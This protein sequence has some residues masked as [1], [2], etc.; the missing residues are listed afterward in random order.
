VSG[1]TQWQQTVA[2]WANPKAFSPDGKSIAV[3]CG[4]QSIRFFDTETGT[5]KHE[6]KA[7]D[8]PQGGRWNDFAIAPQNHMLAIGGIDPEKRGFV[9]VWDLDAAR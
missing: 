6:I 5:V 1:I 2:G 4:G 9:T 7:A 8:S 3:L